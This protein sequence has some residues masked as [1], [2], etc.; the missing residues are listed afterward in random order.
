MASLSGKIAIVT[1]GSSGIGKA[2]AIAF[3]REG[4]KVVVASRREKE[5]QETV[6]QV[7]SAGSEGFFIKTDVSK[8]T[9]VSAM[10][11]KTIATYGH[12]DYAFNNA[13]IEQIPT[14][15]VE[16][17]EETF[18]Q[19]MD[20][21]VK[22]VWLCMK[23]QI[24]QMLVSGGGAIVNMSSIAGMIGAPGLPIY[25]ASKHAVLGL[26]KSVALEYAKEGIRIN[27]VCPGMIE[28][29]LLDRAFANQEVKERLIAMH[30]IGRVGKPE[31]IA[32]AV[33]WLCSDKASFVT[34]QSLPL[35]GGYVAQ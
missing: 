7:Q 18:D 1:G 4:A 31:E 17:T 11:E 25:V 24:P 6:K 15:L 12:L 13:G 28:T 29:D 3:A 8:E 30:P 35:D 34:G 2:T 5:G 22:G 33:V 21:N 9:D 32:E 23:H 14:P 16:Q 26:T 19:V 10:V 27:A 20:I